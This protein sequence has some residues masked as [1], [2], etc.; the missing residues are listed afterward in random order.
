V[1]DIK[2]VRFDWA[3]RFSQ[4]SRFIV[5]RSQSR[6]GTPLRRQHDRFAKQEMQPLRKQSTGT[7]DFLT[8]GYFS[9]TGAR[10]VR[11]SYL[12]RLLRVS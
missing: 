12:V 3:W 8:R 7:Q 9:A 1:D 6:N 4:R 5:S 10:G 2:T 11:R